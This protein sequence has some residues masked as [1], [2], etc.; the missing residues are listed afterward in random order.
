MP[1]WGISTNEGGALS[2]RILKFV[3]QS[4]EINFR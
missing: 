3:T 4:Y 2:K 1:L